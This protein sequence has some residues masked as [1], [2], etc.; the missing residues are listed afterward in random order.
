MLVV[1]VDDRPAGYAS[2]LENGCIGNDYVN[3]LVVNNIYRRRGLA[4][5]LIAALDMALVGRVFISAPADNAAAIKLLE[6]TRWTPAGH[7]VGLLPAGEAEIFFYKDL[8]GHPA[9]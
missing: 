9:P 5:Q 3:K 1:D 8:S 4:K 7:I 6:V 2:W